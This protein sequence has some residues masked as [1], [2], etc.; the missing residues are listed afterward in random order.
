MHAAVSFILK[1]QLSLLKKAGT[2]QVFVLEK[3]E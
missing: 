3:V 1:A 2:W